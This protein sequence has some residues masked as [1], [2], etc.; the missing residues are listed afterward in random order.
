MYNDYYL[1]QINDKMG[2]ILT[3][4]STIIS[5]QE[6]INDNIQNMGTLITCAMVLYV[7]LYFIVRA[8]K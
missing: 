4:T 1:Q 6:T 5:N 2:Q 8:F 3:N 7:L